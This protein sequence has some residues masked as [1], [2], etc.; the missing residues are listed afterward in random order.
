M[1]NIFTRMLLLVLGLLVLSACDIPEPSVSDKLL[2]KSFGSNGFTVRR[3]ADHTNNEEL[4]IDNK[5]RFWQL[6]HTKINQN[7]EHIKNSETVIL[8]YKANGKIDG[9]FANNGQK[10]RA[11]AS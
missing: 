5:G 8:R 11:D 10:I 7:S 6:T 3:T 4:I 9:E 2:D 1:K